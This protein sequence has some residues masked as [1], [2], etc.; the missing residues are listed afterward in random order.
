MRQTGLARLKR[1][2]NES[3][4]GE[5][6]SGRGGQPLLLACLEASEERR[7]REV[8]VGL[9]VSLI[10]CGSSDLRREPLGV[11]AVAVAMAVAPAAGA[12]LVLAL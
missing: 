5:K 4:R 3:M 6:G 11:V 10:G 2:D 9:V 1:D 12:V 7:A 8:A